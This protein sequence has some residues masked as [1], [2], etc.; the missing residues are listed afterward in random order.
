MRGI[1]VARINQA[2]LK[3]TFR[4]SYDNN[5]RIKKWRDIIGRDIKPGTKYDPEKKI[6]VRVT[7]EYDDIELHKRLRPGDVARMPVRR[8]DIVEAA[9][10]LMI[11]EE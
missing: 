8:A 10:Y 6:S 2:R 5:T 11:T 7:K 4:Y 9:G 3:G 1:N